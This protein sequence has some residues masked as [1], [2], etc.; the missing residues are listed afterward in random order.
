MHNYKAQLYLK[1]SPRS[2]LSPITMYSP[3]SLCIEGTLFG[4]VENL[5]FWIKANA[6]EVFGKLSVKYMI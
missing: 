2:V 3:I 4:F 5:R 6:D 1:G